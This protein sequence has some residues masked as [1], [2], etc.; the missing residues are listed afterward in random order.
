YGGAFTLTLFGI[1]FVVSRVST[2]RSPIT[3]D[4]NLI[5]FTI[6]QGLTPAVLAVS[7]FTYGL[8]NAPIYLALTLAVILYTNIIT[9]GMPIVAKMGQRS[10]VLKT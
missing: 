4:R 8:P 10:A 5:L 9:V 1:R 7:T 3:E 6:A 2:F